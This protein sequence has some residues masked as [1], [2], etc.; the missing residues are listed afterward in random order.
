MSQTVALPALH[1]QAPIEDAKA[2]DDD[3]KLWSVTTIIGIVTG[4]GLDQWK[5]RQPISLACAEVEEHGDQAP[6]LARLRNEGVDS[7]VQY[8]T[9]FRWDFEALAST[10]LGTA[11]HSA[12]EH[13]ALTGQRPDTDEIGQFIDAAQEKR[14]P[15]DKIGPDVVATETETIN[16]MLDAF[17]GWLNAFSPTYL[18]AEVTCYSPGYGYA[19]TCDGFLEIDGVSYIFDT[20]TSRDDLNSQGKPK[21]P[22]ADVGLQLAAYRYAEMAAV[23]RPRRGTYYRRRYYLIGPTERE[24]AVPVP[25]VEG[26]LVVYIT[27]KRCEAYPVACGESVFESFLARLDDARFEFE[28]AKGVVGN[29]LMPP[30]K[31]E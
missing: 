30:G 28:T 3:L 17:D 31:G 4:Y 8:L 13:Y 10:E 25:E 14:A 18:A 7:A 15:K 22:Y 12:C 6:W 27:P 1:K 5:I 29:P 24:M 26:G 20:K 11:V 9:A 19:G 21:G 16:S 23:W 2:Q